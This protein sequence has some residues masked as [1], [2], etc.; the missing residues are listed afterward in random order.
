[1]MDFCLICLYFPIIETKLRPMVHKRM[2]YLKSRILGVPSKIL[3]LLCFMNLLCCVFSFGKLDIVCETAPC[4]CDLKRSGFLCLK[5]IN[6]AIA[7]LS[8]WSSCHFFSE[9]LWSLWPDL[10]CLNSHV[11]VIGIGIFFLP[12][13]KSVV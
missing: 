7:A 1:M 10:Y 11:A 4:P 13:R 8:A 5:F 6:R 9:G 2:K 12:D 3:P